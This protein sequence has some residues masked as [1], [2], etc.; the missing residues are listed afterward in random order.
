MSTNDSTGIASRIRHDA[1]AGRFVLIEDGQE[2]ELVYRLE[3]GR[4]TILHTWVPEAVGGRG[5][6]GELVRKAFD[7]ARVEGLKV[8]PACSYSD[9]WMRKH[10]EYEALRE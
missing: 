6:A 4:V 5:I 2:A 9:A 3:P 8:R 10:P 1:D 7:W